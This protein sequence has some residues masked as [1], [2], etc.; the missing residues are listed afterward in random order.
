[1]FVLMLTLALV[2]IPCIFCWFFS[3]VKDEPK[4]EEKLNMTKVVAENNWVPPKVPG[5][6]FRFNMD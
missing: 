4:E 5:H 2:I 6:G 3:Y 1:M